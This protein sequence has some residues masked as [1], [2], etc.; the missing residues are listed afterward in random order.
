MRIDDDWGY[1]NTQGKIV[2][3]PQFFQASPFSEGIASVGVWFPKKKVIDSKVGY[4]SYIDKKGAL[5]TDQ[6]FYVASTFS[7][8]LGVR[9]PIC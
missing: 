3:K 8:G 5:I 1:I 9:L 6:Q 2:I 7:E 4:Y